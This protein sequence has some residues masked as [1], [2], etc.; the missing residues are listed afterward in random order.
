[1]KLY[2]KR[3]FFAE[4]EH[5]LAEEGELRATA[6]RFSTGVEALKIENSRG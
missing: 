2:L 1:M 3:D 6:F 5:L 4:K